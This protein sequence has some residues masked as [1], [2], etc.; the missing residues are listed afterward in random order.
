[1]RRQ[2][3]KLPSSIPADFAYKGYRVRHG[4]AGTVWIEKDS[5]CIG[6]AR[7]DEHARAL[8]DELTAI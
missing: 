6:Y 3:T 8:I 5:F 4:N 1:M 2:P 7:D